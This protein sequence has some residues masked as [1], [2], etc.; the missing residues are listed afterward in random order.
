MSAEPGWLAAFVR[1]NRRRS[2][3]I[4]RRLPHATPRLHDRYAATVARH[5]NARRG[6]TVIDLGAGRS[7]HFASLRR[8]DVGGAIIGVDVSAEQLRANDDLDAKVLVAPGAPLPFGDGTADLFVSRSALE[9]IDG[10]ASVLAEAHRVLRP[11]GH[12]IHVFPSKLAPFAIINRVLP[13]RVARRLLRT[14]VPGSDQRLGFRAYYDHCTAAAMEQLLRRS[15]FEVVETQVS[16][17]QSHYFGFFVPLFL[18]SAGYELVVRALGL[19][20]LAATVLIVARRPPV[21]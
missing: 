6:Q 7:C 17:Y 20:R 16:Y 10:V 3:R 21:G 14:L 5:L 9:H 11:G 8:P 12:T 19:R 1:R 15:G 13:R 18:L 4:E 2:K